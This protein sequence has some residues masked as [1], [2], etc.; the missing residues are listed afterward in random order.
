MKTV[1]TLLAAMLLTGTLASTAAPQ[2][3]ELT[4][5][6]EPRLAI[7][8]NRPRQDLKADKADV[9]VQSFTFDQGGSADAQGWIA[10]DTSADYRPFTHVDDH[11]PPLS[12]TKSLWC[13][14]VANTDNPATTTGS[15]AATETTGTSPG[16]RG[17]SRPRPPI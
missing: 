3:L 11:L 8:S 17:P 16:Y 7:P 5:P 10:I 2:L 13:G 6:V 12:G 15:R 14:A 1:V 9:V 4:K